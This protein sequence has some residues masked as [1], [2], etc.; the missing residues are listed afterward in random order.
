[1]MATRI[2]RCCSA[3]GF[4]TNSPSSGGKL[5]RNKRTI[6]YSKSP[7]GLHPKQRRLPGGH[8]RGGAGARL[9]NSALHGGVIATVPSNPAPSNP[10]AVTRDNLLNAPQDGPPGAVSVPEAGSPRQTGGRKRHSEAGLGLAFGLAAYGI[11][12]VLPLYF[13]V[14]APA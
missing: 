11:W 4:D 1:M 3:A 2:G 10:S 6:D 9:W 8:G 7:A 13:A 5:L 14:L 12:G